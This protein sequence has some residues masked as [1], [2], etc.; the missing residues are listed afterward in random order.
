MDLIQ[1]ITKSRSLFKKYL[2]PEW[3]VSSLPDY[4]TKEIE[5]LYSSKLPSNSELSFGKASAC[6]FTLNHLKIPSHKL[7]VIYYNFPELNNSPLKVTKACADKMM[8][9]YTKEI[10]NPEDSIIL[11]ITE[12]ITE[13]LEKAIED[14]YKKGYE[15]LLE[16]KLSDEIIEENEALGDDKYTLHHFRNIH[17]FH[18]DTL[19]YDI[20]NHK[21]VPKHECIRNQ[22]EI[23]KIYEE[24]NSSS[25][26]LPAILRTDPMAK[27]LRLAPGD[28]CKITRNSE[29]C[30]E[31]VYY[32][33]CQ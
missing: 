20:G 8:S 30:G 29:R 6:N 23:Q 18:I 26:Q 15:T 17:L 10:I 12:P 1:K 2:E 13:N 7:H 22:T 3:D 11:I 4:S 33:I 31:Y 19:S 32:R 16:T 21:L 25:D 5:R 9:L 28:V 27:L 14:T 24:T